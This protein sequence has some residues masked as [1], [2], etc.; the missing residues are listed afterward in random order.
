MLALTGRVGYGIFSIDVGYQVTT[1]LKSG[2]GPS[3]NKFSLGLT[4]S[5]L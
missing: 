4:I 3:M 1:V 2:A 5:G